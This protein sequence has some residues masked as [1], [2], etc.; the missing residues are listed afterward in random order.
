M[1][2][3]IVPIT[4]HEVYKVNKYTVYKNTLGNW[5]CNVDLSAKE[6]LAFGNYEQ[7]V[8]NNPRFKYHIKST[9]KG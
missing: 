6:L 2:V 3:T 5:T 1:T 9:F 7:L 4:D 8:I